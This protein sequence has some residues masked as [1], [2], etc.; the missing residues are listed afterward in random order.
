MASEPALVISMSTAQA[1]AGACPI[2]GADPKS[3][4]SNQAPHTPCPQCGHRIWFTWHAS[5]D[6]HVVTPTGNLI[7]V[8]SLEKLTGLLKLKPGM[9]LV[10]DLS[11]V[12]YL[13]SA[14]LLK[15]LVLKRK[16]AAMHGQVVLRHVHHDI[17]EVLQIT[18]L[19]TM[20]EIET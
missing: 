10:F 8:G 4:P 14:D 16:V 5:G 15:F 11:A 13:S 3:E 6:H 7:P 17:L 2:C 20:L 12:K 1:P 19:D 9:R 18:R